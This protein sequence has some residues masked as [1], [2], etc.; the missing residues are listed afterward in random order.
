MLSI[1][2]EEKPTTP[3][4][5]LGWQSL[6]RPRGVKSFPASTPAPTGANP[7]RAAPSV[8]PPQ[9]QQAFAQ[10]A[11][12]RHLGAFTDAEPPGLDET[13]KAL[14]AIA[15]TLTNKDEAAGQERGKLASDWES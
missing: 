7:F 5:E 1:L 14:Q 8:A 10:A 12:P 13:S 15:K 2:G 3:K 11:R 4:E 9:A 6:Y